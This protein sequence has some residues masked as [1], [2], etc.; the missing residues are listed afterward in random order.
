MKILSNINKDPH[1]HNKKEAGI[2]L[3]KLMHRDADFDFRKKLEESLTFDS[4]KDTMYY[5]PTALDPSKNVY[6]SF[7]LND[8]QV[9]AGFPATRE[10]ASGA[11]F[12]TQIEVWKKFSIISVGFM[13]LAHDIKFKIVQEISF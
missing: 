3:Y 6:E 7:P 9:R 13:L 4:I 10:I 12:T 2:F 1:F 8:F 11:N 5:S